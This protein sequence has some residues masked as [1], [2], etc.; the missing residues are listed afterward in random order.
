MTEVCASS[1]G[2]A[3]HSRTVARNVAASQARHHLPFAA[4]HASAPNLN[5]TVLRRRA[6]ISSRVYVASAMDRE[7]EQ[8]HGSM[9]FADSLLPSAGLKRLC[10]IEIRIAVRIDTDQNGRRFNQDRAM[11]AVPAASMYSMRR[12][13][14]MKPFYPVA[15]SRSCGERLPLSFRRVMLLGPTSEPR[16]PQPCTA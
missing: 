1:R 12:R 3:D 4:R 8:G 10:P 11:I 13:Y 5:E 15:K 14:R 7:S 16:E 2:S 6:C 9:S